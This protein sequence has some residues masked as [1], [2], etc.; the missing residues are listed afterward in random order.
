[1]RR[2]V[3]KARLVFS[4]AIDDRGF[5]LPGVAVFVLDVIRP[6]T[7]HRYDDVEFLAAETSLYPGF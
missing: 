1:L 6:G 7:A 4:I 2:R 3:S 5:G